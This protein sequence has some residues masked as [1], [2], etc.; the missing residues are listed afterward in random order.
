MSEKDLDPSQALQVK[1]TEQLIHSRV[2]TEDVSGSA[3]LAAFFGSDLDTLV[4][5]VI[6]TNVGII[7]LNY[8]VDGNPATP[9]GGTLLPGASKPFFGRKLKLDDMRLFAASPNSVSVS[10]LISE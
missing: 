1:V 10:E 4:G 5:Q 7:N 6:V 9:A 8:Q 3:D 2:K